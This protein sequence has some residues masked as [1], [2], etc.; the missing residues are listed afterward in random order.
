MAHDGVVIQDRT[1]ELESLVVEVL[2]K[3][4]HRKDCPAHVLVGVIAGFL[5]KK[6]KQA[7]EAA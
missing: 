7:G 3:V 5:N 2:L 6:R 4:C 1:D